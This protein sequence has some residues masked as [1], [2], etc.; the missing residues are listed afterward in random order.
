MVDIVAVASYC[1]GGHNNPEHGLYI[2]CH[3]SENDKNKS[4][5]NPML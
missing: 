2:F 3:P 4:L 5:E 1:A